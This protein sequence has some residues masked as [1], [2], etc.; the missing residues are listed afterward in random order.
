MFNQLSDSVK[1]ILIGI[2]II[3]GIILFTNVSSCTDNL[4]GKF[5]VETKDSLKKQVEDQRGAIDTV[6]KLNKDLEQ[7]NKNSIS[8]GKVTT[9]VVVAKN[10]A[11]KKAY[12]KYTDLTNEKDVA[13]LKP[14]LDKSIPKEEAIS[15][16]QITYLWQVYCID[17]SSTQCEKI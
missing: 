15:T 2:V 7:T 16:I 6:N 13:V 17:N 9:E 8:S 5:G 10:T 4:F 11:S 3:F 12:K 1:A 14:P